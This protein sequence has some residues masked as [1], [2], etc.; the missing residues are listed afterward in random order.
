MPYIRK[1]RDEWQIHQNFGQ[2]YEEVC[3]ENTRKEAKDRLKE[4]RENQ[5]EYYAVIVKKRVKIDSK[6]EKWTHTIEP[7]NPAH[8]GL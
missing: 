2:G 7:R 6:G 1:T 8:G 5:P 3:A 4:Y